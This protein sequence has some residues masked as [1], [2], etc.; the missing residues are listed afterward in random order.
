MLRWGEGTRGERPLTSYRGRGWAATGQ[1][2]RARWARITRVGRPGDPQP[3]QVR[4]PGRPTVNETY[5][6]HRMNTWPDDTPGLLRLPSGRLVRGRGLR[7][8]PPADPPDFGLY[9][10]GKPPPE[11]TWETRWLRCRDFSTP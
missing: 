4:S 10:L 11:S 7:H 3:P 5:Y 6:T 2:D 8:G 1:R 9:L